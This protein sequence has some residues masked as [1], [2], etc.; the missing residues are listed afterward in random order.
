MKERIKRVRQY[1]GM[2]QAE[3]AQ[4][5]NVTPRSVQGWE[6]GTSAPHPATLRRI[7]ALAG[8]PISWF[9]ETEV[10]A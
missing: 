3:F 5:V 9:Y 8:K 1:Q 7:S 6:A 10:A 4:S 2:T